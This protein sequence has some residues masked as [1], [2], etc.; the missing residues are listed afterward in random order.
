MNWLTATKGLNF[1]RHPLALNSV[2]AVL[3]C[4]GLMVFGAFFLS[5]CQKTAGSNTSDDSDSSTRQSSS[6]DTLVAEI[7]ENLAFISRAI[8]RGETISPKVRTY[9]NDASHTNKLPDSQGR[10]LLEQAQEAAQSALT[11]SNFATRTR[12]S[13]NYFLLGVDDRSVG[14]LSAKA[15][16]RTF[17]AC[18]YYRLSECQSYDGVIPNNDQSADYVTALFEVILNLSNKG[19]D[20][21]GGQ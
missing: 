5:S 20:R 3:L 19:E 17:Q 10:K 7:S 18:V 16:E 8:V 21:L 1:G 13:I 6:V 14:T 12:D 4:F 11:G 15:L 9:L 2:N